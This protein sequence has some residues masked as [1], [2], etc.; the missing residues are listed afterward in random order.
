[1]T[2]RKFY[3]QQLKIYI[4][5]YVLSYQKSR[6]FILKELCSIAHK[7]SALGQDLKTIKVNIF[8]KHGK[9][10]T[11]NGKCIMKQTFV[12]HFFFFLERTKIKCLCYDTFNNKSKSASFSLI[13]II[14][15][16]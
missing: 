11:K 13:Y 12:S 6:F 1:M 9:E 8:K 16:V 14:L 5:L 2:G 4:K 7:V 10:L 15:N 3:H